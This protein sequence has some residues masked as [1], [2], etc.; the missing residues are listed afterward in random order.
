MTKGMDTKGRGGLTV[1]SLVE[2]KKISKDPVWRKLVNLL[3]FLATFVATLF[4]FPI[5]L[6]NHLPSWLIPRSHSPFDKYYASLPAIKTFSPS[7]LSKTTES[8]PLSVSFEVWRPSPTWKR[9][10]PGPPAFHICVV[11][12]RDPFPSLDQLERLYNSVAGKFPLRGKNGGKV[13]VS[14]VDCGVSNYLTLDEGLFD[15]G[16][17]A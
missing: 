1:D 6:I 13:V 14:V 16:A 5:S 9:K 8:P 7:S 17:A 12:G 11:D 15:F 10:S 3:L 4:T 2:D